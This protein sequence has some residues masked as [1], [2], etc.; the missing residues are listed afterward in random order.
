[1]EVILKQP[2]RNLGDQDDIVKVKPGYAR[3]F[4]IP[5]GLAV[6]ATESARKSLTEK[7]RQVSHKQEF[8]KTKALDEAAKLEGV[9]VVIET[10]AG[11]DGKLFGSVTTLQIVNRLK[12]L[13]IEIDRRSITVD[14]IRV[15]GEY[16]AKIHFHKEVKVELPIEVIRKEG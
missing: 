3:N 9:K 15:I 5:Q 12:D 8:L 2:V 16:T 6:M 11:N 1:M 10:L 7:K 4:L 14:D 13:G